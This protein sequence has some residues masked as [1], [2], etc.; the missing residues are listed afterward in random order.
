MVD[1]YIIDRRSALHLMNIFYIFYN[2]SM[3]VTKDTKI[4]I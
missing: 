2:L 4:H 1:E 3:V